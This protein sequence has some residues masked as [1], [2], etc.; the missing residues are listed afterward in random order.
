MV[1][2]AHY[3]VHASC[4]LLG[5]VMFFFLC[6]KT[7]NTFLYF[8][9]EFKRTIFLTQYTNITLQTSLIL[10][11]CRT[12]VIHELRKFGPRSPLSLCGPV[13]ELLCAEFEGLRFD[14]S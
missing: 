12:R 10:E 4:I 13:V 14:S 7:K 1:S 5:S 8:F 3:E 6:D 11:V 2:M 9:T